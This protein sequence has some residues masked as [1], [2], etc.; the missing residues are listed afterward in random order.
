MMKRLRSSYNRVTPFITKDGSVIRELMHPNVHG[1]RKQSLAEAIVPPESATVLHRHHH[2]E[3]LYHIT[4]GEGL[5]RLGEDEFTVTVG[6]TICIPPG[7]AHSLSNPGQ[8]ELRL[9][10]SSS[11]PYSDEDTELLVESA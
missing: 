4:A 9:L 10:C 2:S 6:D 8:T 11:P 1:N 3:E 7:I 5:M